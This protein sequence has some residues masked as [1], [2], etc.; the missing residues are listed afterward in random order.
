ML[1]VGLWRAAAAASGVLFL[2]VVLKNAWLS[3]DFWIVARQVEQLFA[4][5]GLRW[6]PHE[7]M[8]LF[9]SVIGFW[10]TAF[11]RLL[12][13]DY[14][15]NFAVQAIALNGIALAL[16]AWLLQTPAKWSAAVLL[17]TASNSYMD[18]TWS[19]LHNPV[20]HAL[21]VGV[22][23]LVKRAAR[24]EAGPADGADGSAGAA[25]AVTTSLALAALAGL[26]PLFRHDFALLAWPPA[27]YALWQVRRSCGPRARA[28]VVALLLL[29]LAAWTVFAVVY[30]G[31]PLP[32]T[33][34]NKLGSGIPRVVALQNGLHY[35]LFALRNDPPVL[36]IVLAALVWMTWRKGWLRALAA[37][38]ALHLLYTLYAGADYMGGRFFTYPYLLS[39]IVIVHFWGG[40]TGTLTSGRP[41]RRQARS[42]TGRTPPAWLAAAG[43]QGTPVL[44]VLACLWMVSLPHTPLRSPFSYHRTDLIQSG[45][46]ADERAAYHSATSILDYSAFRRGDAATYPDHVSV[47][48]GEIMGRA[49][50]PVI[51][52]CNMGMEPFVAG[53]EHVFIDVYGFS[54]VLQALLPEGGVHRRPGHNI[55]RLP[56][57]YLESVA[58][59][60]AAIAD[61]RL[62]RYYERLRLVTQSDSLFA[63][64]RLRAILHV[65]LHRP[66]VAH[67]EWPPVEGHLRWP[68]VCAARTDRRLLQLLDE[69]AHRLP[70]DQIN[71]SSFASFRG[72]DPPGR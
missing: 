37:G 61:E 55:R 63:A 40:A 35:Y 70:V 2:F 56:E 68:V 69:N 64:G 36:L 53:T 21:L 27:I 47:R 66:P 7:R 9:T 29:P 11:G 71:D 20:G 32:M 28:A 4:G 72:A 25:V 44:A 52:L 45:G 6:N 1:R 50:L 38:A 13:A 24:V 14:F 39:V 23:I 31:F 15:L 30:F 59:G 18:F 46:I 60:R 8:Q 5:N 34:Y 41:A 54:D 43:R 10:L 19:G 42:G 3:D 58:S 26:A 12:T 22:I 57:G 62:N 67:I 17:L 65:N 51:H 33:A 48:L 49:A 16:L